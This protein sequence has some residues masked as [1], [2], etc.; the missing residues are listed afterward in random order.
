VTA[1]SARLLFF[2]SI[3]LRN[4]LNLFVFFCKNIYSRKIDT[5]KKRRK[6][7]ASEEN[8][9]DKIERESEPKN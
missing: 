6:A 2:F 3:I 7:K 5:K 1:R 4:L 9:R 8:K